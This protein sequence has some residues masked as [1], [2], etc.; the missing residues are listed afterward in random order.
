MKAIPFILIPF[1]AIVGGYLEWADASLEDTVIIVFLSTAIALVIVLGTAK[2]SVKH[3]S[4][5]NYAEAK[6]MGYPGSYS[7]WKA[8]SRSYKGGAG[9]GYK[10]LACAIIV[11]ALCWV[12][13]FVLR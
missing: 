6:I 10:L 13:F 5:E 9:G 3:E 1:A 8:K 7:Q 12:W 2:A 4:L 11:A